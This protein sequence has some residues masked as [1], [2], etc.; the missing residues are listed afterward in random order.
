MIMTPWGYDYVDLEDKDDLIKV[1][2]AGA[3]ALASVHGTEY[4][5]GSSPELLYP[6]AGLF[7]SVFIGGARRSV[8]KCC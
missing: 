2:Q 7:Y 6:A 8:S 1:A 4:Q 3:K 5:V